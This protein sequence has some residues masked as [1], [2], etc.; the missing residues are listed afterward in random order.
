MMYGMHKTTVYLPEELKVAL[1]R[2][3]REHD[4]SEADLI[5]E[6]VQMVT[7]RLSYPKPRLPLFSGGPPDL[8][9]RA[10]DY[11]EGFGEDS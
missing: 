10:D 8:A 2:A 5:R 11:L 3:A 4:R 7:E 9:E 1:E 6:G